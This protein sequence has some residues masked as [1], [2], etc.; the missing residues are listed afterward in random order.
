MTL[1][2]IAKGTLNWDVPLNQQLAQLDANITAVAGSVANTMDTTSNQTVTGTKTFATQ[3][4]FQGN[5]GAAI[6]ISSNTNGDTNARFA[7]SANGTVNWGSGSAATDVTL[8]RTGTSSLTVTG[9]LATTGTLSTSAGGRIVSFSSAGGTLIYS[10][11]V[12]G[13]SQDRFE[14]DSNGRLLWSAGSGSMDTNLYRNAAG[15]LKTD[16]SLSVAGNL[17]VGG[18]GSVQT[19][20]KSS[21]QAVTNSTTYTAD[22]ALTVALAS[23]GTYTFVLFLVYDTLSAA[24]INVRMSY[25]G[26]SS[27]SRYTAD[28]LQGETT[29]STGNI[30]RDVS[31][32]GTG[33]GVNGGAGSGVAIAATIRGS[34]QATGAGNLFF[35]WAQNTAN[36][37]ATNVQQGSYLEVR[38]VA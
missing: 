16:Q 25:S 9:N 22:S 10:A 6:N 17:T 20:Y 36:V 24:G 23:A 33:F 28:I 34:V 19:A 29:G 11:F 35:E 3:T 21:G 1:T 8:S 14:I 18:I 12:N 15:V 32:L 26:T 27:F 37:T 30:R 5:S 4:N 13:D 38:R 7:L 31:S 2:A